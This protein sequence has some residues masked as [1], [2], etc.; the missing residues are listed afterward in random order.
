MLLV[1]LLWGVNFAIA[2]FGL[3]SFAPIFF[4]ARVT[5]SEEVVRV[6]AELLWGSVEA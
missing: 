2:K 6:P 1:Q 3:D 4:V 5:A